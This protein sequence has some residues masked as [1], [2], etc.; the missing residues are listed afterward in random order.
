MEERAPVGEEREKE[1]MEA[2][3]LERR[4]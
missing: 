1:N 3:W 2:S 4:E